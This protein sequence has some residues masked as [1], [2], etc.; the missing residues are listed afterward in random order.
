MMKFFLGIVLYIVMFDNIVD[1][2]NI[3]LKNLI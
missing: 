3:F 2:Y 1:F